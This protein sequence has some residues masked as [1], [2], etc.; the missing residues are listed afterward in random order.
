[1][2][3]GKGRSAGIFPG[4]SAGLI[5]QWNDA[6]LAGVSDGTSLTAWNGNA[7]GNNLAQGGASSIQPVCRTGV[8]NGHRAV[9]FDSDAYMDASVTPA[10]QKTY[11][12]LAIVSAYPGV[13]SGMQLAADGSGRYWTFDTTAAGGGSIGLNVFDG[14]TIWGL[15]AV[16]ATGPQMLGFCMDAGSLD[17]FVAKTF[18]TNSGSTA[19]CQ[20]N[21]VGKPTSGSAQ[22]RISEFCLWNRK[23]S[24]GE[25]TLLYD[26]YFKPKYS[27]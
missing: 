13:Q 23:L 8:L 22:C 11:T 3:L 2:R 15:A 20:W 6:T 26:N 14:T 16:A 21:R 7:G 1:M 18:Y 4:G 17:F 24:Q 5:A 19:N 12:V 9:E 25:I 27:L 10:A